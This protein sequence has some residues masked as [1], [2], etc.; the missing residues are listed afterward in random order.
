MD[1]YH[2]DE[3]QDRRVVKPTAT[4]GDIVAVVNSPLMIRKQGTSQ[5]E[6]GANAKER[7]FAVEAAIAVERH[8]SCRKSRIDKAVVIRILYLLVNISDFVGQYNMSH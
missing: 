5:D 4:A 3:L 7:L 2:S 1:T 6:N 8:I